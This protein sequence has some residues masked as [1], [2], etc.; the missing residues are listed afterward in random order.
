MNDVANVFLGSLICLIIVGGTIA[1]CYIGLIAWSCGEIA[2]ANGRDRIT[3]IV[4]GLMF[5]VFALI[6]VRFFLPPVGV[7]R[8]R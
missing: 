2:E 4:W 3:W 1:I 8:R 6:L 7:T 5:N